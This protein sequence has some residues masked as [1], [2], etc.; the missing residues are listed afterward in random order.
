MTLAAEHFPGRADAVA[1]D[2]VDGARM[3]NDAVDDVMIR[4]NFG[5]GG[6]RAAEGREGR[7]GEYELSHGVSPSSILISLG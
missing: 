6:D 5:V 3:E 2:S 7:E 1:D 4:E